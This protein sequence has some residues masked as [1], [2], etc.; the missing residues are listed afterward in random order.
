MSPSNNVPNQ[1]PIKSAVPPA[2]IVPGTGQARRPLNAG[3]RPQTVRV[4]DG[5]SEKDLRT[6]PQ[7]T[8]MRKGGLSHAAARLDRRTGLGQRPSG[9]VDVSAGACPGATPGGI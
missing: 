1:A 3:V 8:T 4:S 6:P 2:A 9:L 7:L 5:L